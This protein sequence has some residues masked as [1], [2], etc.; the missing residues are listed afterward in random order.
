M[1][2]CCC[3]KKEKLESEFNKNKNGKYGLASSCKECNR[4]KCKE[5][6]KENKQKHILECGNLKKK[7]YGQVK[8]N[9][10]RLKEEV[11][12]QVSSCNERESCCLDFHHLLD[13]ESLVSKMVHNACSWSRVVVEI[14]KCV[15]VCANCHRKIHKGLIETPKVSLETIIDEMFGAIDTNRIRKM[16]KASCGYCGKYFG[17]YNKKYCSSWCAR[18]A[19]RKVEWP[20]VQQLTYDINN[21]NW[22]QIGK[23]YGV[24]DKSVK[25]WAMSYGI[26]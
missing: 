7:Y 4:K 18:M 2:K 23:K 16:K 24:S 19:S 5:Y 25:K 13:K 14:K 20:S 17:T 11:G 21:M 9:I 22:R 26:L 1:K 10:N 12:C 3:C 8:D 15:L 6:Y